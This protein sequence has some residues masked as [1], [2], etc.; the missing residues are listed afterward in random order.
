MKSILTILLFFACVTVYGQITIQRAQDSLQQYHLGT[1]TYFEDF[2]GHSGYGARVILT[3]DG[4]A[5]GFGDGDNGTELIKLDKNGKVQWRKK[6]KKQ[7]EETEPQCVVQDNLGNFYVFILNYNPNGYR[8]GAERVICFNKAGTLLWDKILGTYTLLNR[9][10]V[11]YVHMLKDGRIEMRGHVVR[12]KPAEGKDPSYH[13][14]QGWYS[15]KGILTEKTGEIIDWSNPV[16]QEK[17]K[18]EK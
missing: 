7:F 3:T 16:W 1:S 8:G 17:F 10:T 18:P 2:M 4:G 9:P 15:S 5:A 13:Y 12:E 6:I 14:W 11:S